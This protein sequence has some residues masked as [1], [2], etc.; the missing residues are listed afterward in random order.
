MFRHLKLGIAVE[1]PVLNEWKL[2]T[3]NSATQVYTSGWLFYD[4]VYMWS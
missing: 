2:D 1:I 3:N 4:Y